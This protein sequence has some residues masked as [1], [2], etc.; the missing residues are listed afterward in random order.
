[1]KK[2]KDTYI[3]IVEDS[4]TQAVKL[5]YIIEQYG[6]RSSYAKNGKE[7][8]DSIK[9]EKPTIIISDIMMPEMN[10][11]ELCRHVKSDKRT[12]DIPVILLSSLSDPRDVIL[13]LECGADNFIAKPAEEKQFLSRIEMFLNIRETEETVPDDLEILIVEDSPTQAELLKHSIQ[14]HGYKARVANNG[15]EALAMMNENK[16]TLVISDIVMPEMDGFELCKQIKGDKNLNNVPVMLLSVLKDK[17][18]ISKGFD[19][20]ADAFVPKPFSDN[21]LIP[22]VEDLLESLNRVESNKEG[23]E[24]SFKGE[25]YTI[26]SERRQIMNF[27]LSVY[28]SSIRQNSE[29]IET[30]LEMR[31]L[32]ERLESIV[33]E[34]TAVLKEEIKERKTIE[35]VLQRNYDGQF[36][37]NSLLNLSLENIP[38]D[39]LLNRANGL[40]LSIERFALESMGG[41]FLILDDPDVLVLKAHKGFKEGLKQ[42]C[43]DDCVNRRSLSTMEIQYSKPGDHMCGLHSNETEPHCHYSIPMVFAEKVLGVITVCLG[44]EYDR[45][46]EDET[47]LTTISKTLAGIIQRKQAEDELHMYKEHLENLVRDRTKELEI[48]KDK[49][50]TAN[51]TKSEFLA[52]M[53]HELRTPLN[54]IIGFSEILE[55]KTFGKINE[56]QSKYVHNIRTSGMHLLQLINDILDLSKVEA[57]KMSVNYNEFS[58]PDAMRDIS[59]II[60]AQITKKNI[61]LGME[62]DERLVSINADQKMFKQIMYNLLSNA[63]KFTLDDGQITVKAEVADRFVKISVSDT[64]IGIKPEDQE[65][66]FKEFQQ[67][68]SKTSRAYEGTGLGLPLTRK[69]VEMHG[70]KIW[71]ESEFEKGSTFIFTLPLETESKTSPD[72]LS[73]V[74]EIKELKGSVKGSLVL[75]V[76]DDPKSSE[77]LSI[78]LIQNG[79][80][81][82]NVFHG[83]EVV[84]KAR[85]LKPIAI[86]LDINLPGKDG[87]QVL[88][89]LKKMPETREIPVI[90]TS[91]HDDRKK[92]FNLGAFDYVTKPIS[93]DR[94]LKALD[95]CNLTPKITGKPINVLVVDDEPK[96]VE[97]VS[98]VLEAEGY[99]VQK[100]YGGEEGVDLAMKG[101]PDL[102]ILDLMMPKVDGFEVVKK[103]R[104]HS[105]LKDVPIIIS[106]AKDLTEN[107]LE[108]L[109]GKVSYIEQKGNFTKEELIKDVKRIEKKKQEKDARTDDRRRKERR[110]PKVD[111]RNR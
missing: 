80:Q 97:L 90:I 105:R 39:E 17:K 84:K 22:K 102:I 13:G 45:N 51:R 32:N 104:Q 16:P 78:C 24:I 83:N 109:K 89:E 47:L 8:L 6:H 94:L 71:V 33:E 77:L 55:D 86:T 99:H 107:D 73:V 28:E 85:E 106:T 64:G 21:T 2:D 18:A 79:Y 87:W 14:T 101:D 72:E 57:G 7:A 26:T 5:Q 68:D 15:K 92:G 88:G 62:L 48:T 91:I 75:V 36:I 34:R 53:S 76:E 27:L 56:K 19:Y 67:I 1:M 93:K 38:L 41:I 46:K 61:S 65:L 96:T 108:Q 31:R 58:I 10:G 98:T 110:I 50:E 81:V 43:L 100:A 111:R 4:P 11:Y 54:S 44:I 37:V 23:V 70:G 12:K 95:R 20:G 3:L 74:E 103:L 59:T 69:F 29:L 82:A 52:N 63:V 9:K 42:V 40:I 30:Q 49:A 60:I 25:T 35:A 66:V